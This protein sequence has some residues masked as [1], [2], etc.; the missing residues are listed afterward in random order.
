MIL[1]IVN[2]EYGFRMNTLIDVKCPVLKL[3]LKSIVTDPIIPIKTGGT[4]PKVRTS[5]TWQISPV[6][7]L[8]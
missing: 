2:S 8:N 7:E 3:I 6:T 5:G 1:S 4:I